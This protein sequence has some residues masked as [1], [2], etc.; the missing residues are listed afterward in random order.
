MLYTS[1]RIFAAGSESYPVRPA[2]QGTIMAALFE[3]GDR[4]WDRL[5]RLV[6]EYAPKLEDADTSEQIAGLC[7]ALGD[8]CA[9]EMIVGDPRVEILPW[10]RGFE[11]IEDVATEVRL[12]I[13]ASGESPDDWDVWAIARDAYVW[14]GDAFFERWDVDFWGIVERHALALN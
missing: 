11:T 13:E 3:G 4:A 1:T 14:E 8:E 6:I 12:M 5:D 9:A 2:W 10:A 7:E